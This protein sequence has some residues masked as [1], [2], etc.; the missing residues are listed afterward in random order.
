[1]LSAILSCR[2]RISPDASLIEGPCRMMGMPCSW[3]ACSFLS[4]AMPPIKGGWRHQG[5]SPTYIYTI[6]YTVY[7]TRYRYIISF[8]WLRI[9]TYITWPDM[10]LHYTSLHYITLY[11]LHYIT[12]HDI[13]LHCI[14]LHYITY[15]YLWVHIPLSHYQIELFTKKQS[16]VELTRPLGTMTKDKDGMIDSILKCDTYI[17]LSHYAHNFQALSEIHTSLAPGSA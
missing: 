9:R 15:V 16:K 1:M 14:A 6:S 12:W 4:T 10:T 11:T 17:Y 7:S 8:I 13:T 5:G 3:P 2:H